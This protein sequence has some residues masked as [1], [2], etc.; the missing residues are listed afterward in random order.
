M[1]N[2]LVVDD[3]IFSRKLVE[4][5]LQAFLNEDIIVFFSPNGQHALEALNCNK[6]DVLIT[7]IMM[8]VMDGMELY[9]IVRGKSGLVELPIIVMSAV[10]DFADISSKLQNRNTYYLEKPI[11]PAKLVEYIHVAL[12][13]KKLRMRIGDSKEL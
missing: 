13:K 10:S 8:P 4:E 9:E 1:I 5:Y 2:I 3:D 12:S 7:D 11:K 6:F